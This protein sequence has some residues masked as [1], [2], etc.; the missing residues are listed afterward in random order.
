[1]T[2]AL[3]IQNIYVFGTHAVMRYLAPDTHTLT[4]YQH[5]L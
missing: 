1:M 4:H 2:P 3:E 5:V